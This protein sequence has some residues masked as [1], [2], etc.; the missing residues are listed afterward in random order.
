MLQAL[1]TQISGAKFL[2]ERTTALLADE[3]RVGKTGASIMAADDILAEQI[4]TITTASG[5][6]VWKSGWPTWS[7]Y[8]RPMQILA[9]GSDKLKPS[10]ANVVVGWAG[11]RN[12][13]IR[14]QLLKR[15]FDLIIIDEAHA[16]KNF[17]A[18]QT[19]ALYGT[20]ID[21]GDRLGDA[22]ALTPRAKRVWALSGT[23]VPNDPGDI[24]PMMRRL[25]PE[26]LRENGE[27]PDV[28][29]YEDFMRRYT[30][31]RPFKI[32]Q[33][34]SIQ[35]FVRGRNLAELN[36]RLK[37]F[38]LLRTQ[39]DVGILAPTY[40]MLP[41]IVSD[42]MRAQAEGDLDRQKILAAADQNDTRSLE[43]HMGPLR[44]VT[45][46]IV[47]RAVIDAVKE[48]FALGL[49]KIVLA[50]WH[51]EVGKILAEGLERFGVL[52]IDGST[53]NAARPI[54]VNTFH[55]D[56]SKRVMLGQIVAAG[57]AVDFSPASQLWF[58]ESSFVPKDMKQMSLRITNITQKR[59]PIVRVCTLQGSIYEALQSRLLPKWSAIREVLA[60]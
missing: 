35:V 50:Y 9:S 45:G 49:D 22:V 8:P 32:S 41:L 36:A 38:F 51:K 30:E 28:T 18:K 54:L 14:S 33:W 29:R 43:M 46:E 37:G 23:A 25:C 4:L 31:R 53:S 5:R 7:P 1:P 55:N 13:A 17:E 52:M 60:Q 40:E 39:Q 59:Q 19:Q 15:N 11:I 57:E 3:P 42:R 10:T 48:E 47:A 12:H 58:V 26:R 16:A 21:G 34:K 44:R 6:G 27:W 24:Y 20:L 56:A 2:A